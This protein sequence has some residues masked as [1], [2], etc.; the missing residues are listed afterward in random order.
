MKSFQRVHAIQTAI[1]GWCLLSLFAGCQTGKVNE[2]VIV[3]VSGKVTLDGESLADANV[4]FIPFQ[5]SQDDEELVPVSVATTDNEGRYTLRITEQT[6]GAVAGWHY[7]LISKVNR[8]DGDEPSSATPPAGKFG[9][10]TVQLLDQFELQ[11]N[12]GQPFRIPGETLPSYYNSDSTLTFRVPNKPTTNA[13]FE[14]TT[15]DPLLSD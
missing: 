8:T 11:Q 13:N 12:V 15:I 6:E 4:V 14:L 3:A 1:T 9:Q 7:V 2:T 10:L 5:A